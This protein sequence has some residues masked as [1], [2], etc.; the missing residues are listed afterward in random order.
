M[1]VSFMYWFCKDLA[2]ASSADDTAALEALGAHFALVALFLATFALGGD[3]RAGDLLTAFFAGDDD[4]FFAEAL[5]FWAP[6]GEDFL[7]L[8][9]DAFF[10]STDADDAPFS[11]L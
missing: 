6:P 7:A 11:I 1:V 5:A 10:V 3:F 8:V 9:G 4:A 2:R